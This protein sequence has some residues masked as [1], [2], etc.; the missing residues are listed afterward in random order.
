MNPTANQPKKK[1]QPLTLL[2]EHYQ[3]GEICPKCQNL[4]TPAGLQNTDWGTQFVYDCPECQSS[5]AFV[6]ITEFRLFEVVAQ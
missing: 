6:P 3:A 1:L 2:P 5:F 4:L